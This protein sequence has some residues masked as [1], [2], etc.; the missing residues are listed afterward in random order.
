MLTMNMGYNV[1]KYI[2]GVRIMTKLMKIASA[3]IVS[4]SLLAIPLVNFAASTHPA[5]LW[6]TIDDKTKKARSI[7]RIWE[8][9]GA[10]YGRIVKVYKQPGD[11]GFCRNCPGEFKDKPTKGLRL[12]WGLKQTGERIWDGG[13]IIDPKIGKIYRAKITVA[14]DGKSLK[15]RGYIGFSL[16]GRTQVWYRRR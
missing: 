10:L 4:L 5:G 7:V 13:R 12:M 1:A 8:S 6:T 15:L 16:L 9:N 3:L 11:T 14:P 2:Q